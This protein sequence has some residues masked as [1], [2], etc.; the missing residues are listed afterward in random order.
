MSTALG[1]ND[2]QQHR[3]LTQRRTGD[4]FRVNH[5]TSVH[6]CFLGNW[7]I[8]IDSPD[9][10]RHIMPGS[11]KLEKRVANTSPPG[12]IWSSVAECGGRRFHGGRRFFR[13]NLAEDTSF[14][15]R[16]ENF[17]LQG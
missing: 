6:T 9:W 10:T 2:A 3:A 13:S 4:G 11:G 5:N 7:P 12:R 8:Q 16:G 17:E 14:W 1:R 15:M